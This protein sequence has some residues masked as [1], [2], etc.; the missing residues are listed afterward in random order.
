MERSTDSKGKNWSI[1][2]FLFFSKFVKI[3]VES[4]F[5]RESEK[6]REK[7]REREEYEILEKF[8]KIIK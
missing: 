1:L 4:V 7:H 8:K 2:F 5:A 3:L 6:E